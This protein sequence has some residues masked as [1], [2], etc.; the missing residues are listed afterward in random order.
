MTNVIGTPVA[1]FSPAQLRLQDEE[2]FVGRPETGR[3]LHGT[4]H[5]RAGVRCEL[6]E[7][8]TGMRGMIDVADRLGMAF[9]TETRNLIERQFGAGRDDQVVVVDR[10]AVAELDMVLGR[11]DAPCA[12]RQQ[13]HALALHDVRQIN[14]DLFA[15]AP[16]D[17]DPRIGWDEMIDGALRD[18]AEAVLL[19]QLRQ[20]FIG[21]QCS[22][23]TSS[24]YDNF[25]HGFTSVGPSRSAD[26]APAV[27]QRLTIYS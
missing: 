25:R 8:L 15:L 3:P 22:A 7:G 13:S 11:V 2:E 23:Q 9:W 12:L 17:C 27:V 20:Q 18:D 16:A 4:D 26:L 5:D 14:L 10:G 24:D 6:L 1:Q 21:H 19:S